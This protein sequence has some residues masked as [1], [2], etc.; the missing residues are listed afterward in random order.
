MAFRLTGEPLRILHFDLE[1][2]PLSWYGGDFVTKEVTAVAW[3]WVG[4]KS[5]SGQQAVHSLYLTREGVEFTGWA[6]QFL[7]EFAKADMVTGHFI[8]GFDL[9]V[10]NGALLECQANSLPTMLTHDTKLDLKRF[11]GLSKSQENLAAMLGIPAPKVGMNQA[12]WRAANRL[13]DKGIRLSLERVEGDV[14]Q[15]VQLREA[16]L[17]LGMLAAPRP[18]HPSSSGTA[19]YQA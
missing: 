5:K 3:S 7:H 2:R 6:A 16:L 12:A 4:D 14:L 1:C 9:P 15:H 13:T 11:S 17:N 18:W 10:L 8:R 19:K